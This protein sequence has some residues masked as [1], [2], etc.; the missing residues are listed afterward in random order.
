MG[1]KFKRID[2]LAGSAEFPTTDTSY[3]GRRARSLTIMEKIGHAIL[4][5]NCGW[6]LDSRTP[7]VTDFADVPTKAAGETYPGLFFRNTTSGCK[8]FVAYI[9]NQVQYGMKDFGGTGDDL[10]RCGSGTGRFVSSLCMSIIPGGSSSEFGDLTATTFLP[11][12]ATR[13]IGTDV[14][15]ESDGQNGAFASAPT[16]GW[17]YS[18]GLFVSPY[19]IAVSTAKSQA[20]PGN[21]GVPSYAV[22][23]IIGTLANASDTT[24]QAKYGV[25][26]FRNKNDINTCA[27]GT[28][29]I[30]GYSQSTRL[31]ENGSIGLLGTDP[32][33]TGGLD[34]YLGAT[35]T[36]CCISRADGSW[37][38]G[39][40]DTTYSS[41]LYPSE[42]HQL[43]GYLFNSTNNGKSRWVPME[44][45]VVSS[46]LDTYGIVPGDGF[47]GYF[48][49][50]LFRCALGT[51][52][53]TF[54]NGNFI[55]CDSTYN[56]L[57]GWDPNNT[58]SIA[59]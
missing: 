5:C 31:G 20:N 45:V 14:T 1:F 38:N 11:S 8:L 32:V 12:D 3:T 19:C 49:T 51:Y 13:V 6:A 44:V 53:Q 40:D 29:S 57:I 22:G 34:S 33:G 55:C 56:L 35:H 47:K 15:Y 36:C 27:E 42:A 10:F 54:D 16:A 9:A 4:D 26:G 24:N 37:V 18:Y 39:S 46:D 50:E 2:L 48:D 41:V 43:S 59:G 7:T 23:R 25:I 28:Y 52:G 21:L 30:I 17:I 58:D